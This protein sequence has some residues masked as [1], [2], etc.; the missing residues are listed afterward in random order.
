MKPISPRLHGYVDYAAVGLM[1]AAPSLLG[2]KGPARTLSYL[3]AGTYL[4]V[5]VFT[6][7]PLGLKKVIP[8]PT[9]GAIELGSGPALL[10]LPM[11]T[12]A[13]KTGTERAYFLSL[14][15]TVLAAYTLTDW[16]GNTED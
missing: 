11:L 10:A 7:M 12:G 14:L 6:D 2:L 3:F 4:G 1:L 8:F 13:F 9:H 15:G 16:Q 5:S